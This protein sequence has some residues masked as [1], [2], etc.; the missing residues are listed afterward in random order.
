MTQEEFER[1]LPRLRRRMLSVARRFFGNAE[2]AEDAVQEALAKLWQRCQR[3]SADRNLEA[4]AVMTAK[5][6]CVE[7]YRRKEQT[8]LLDEG[9]PLQ[10]ASDGDEADASLVAQERREAFDK[11]VAQLQKREQQLLRMRYDDEQST[12]EIASR[13]GIPHAS[14]QSMLSMAKKKLKTYLKNKEEE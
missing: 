11:A 8:V 1:H 14:V 6:E 3:L 10:I 13:T 12:R 4:L 7:L 2:D 5:N 9:P